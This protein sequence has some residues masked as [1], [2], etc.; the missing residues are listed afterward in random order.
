MLKRL[1]IKF[2]VINM[3]F[4]TLILCVMF[5]IVL[6]LT[7]NNLEA[8]SIRMMQSVVENPYK[9]ER[10]EI[11]N[12]Q[13]RLPFFSIQINEKGEVIAKGGSYFDLSNEEFIAEL[14]QASFADDNKT[15]IIDDYGLRYLKANVQGLNYLVFADTSIEN[16]TIDNLIEN[17][18][19]I[20]GISWLV[21][22]AISLVF[23][24]WAV[25]PVAKAWASQKQFVADAS[26]E[27]KTPLTVIMTNAELLQDS[28]YDDATRRQFTDSI[29]TV[30]KQMRGLIEDLLNLA[31][32]D[33]G[34][35]DMQF[36]HIDYSTLVSNAIL[37]FEAL[38]YERQ[39]NL[40]CDIDEGIGVNGS[41]K[42]LGQI[43]DILLDNAGKYAIPNGQVMI[44]L[45]RYGRSHCILS[46]INP[47]ECISKE[48][49]KKIFKR[50]YRIDKARSRSGSYGL[51]LSIAESIVEKHH[52]RIWAENDG[53]YTRINVLLPVIN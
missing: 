38:F 3:F 2:V 42:H 14:I 39:L 51:G 16:V 12:N 48:D 28:S 46:V 19:I 45:K 41:A 7:K 37:P 6:K 52:G 15:G 43:V 25:K 29:L 20:G 5:G 1:R 40:A 32:I 13:V 8:E 47:S 53:G 49:L 31:K 23:A 11:N 9:L 34:A 44:M 18:L 50:F 4:V 21:F 10:P 33:N 30:S 24:R 26:H 36:E 22:F 35:V 17:C 27:L